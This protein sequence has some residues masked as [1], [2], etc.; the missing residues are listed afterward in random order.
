MLPAQQDTSDNEHPL[1]RTELEQVKSGWKVSAERPFRL[2]FV[3]LFSRDKAISSIW[4]LDR[5][6]LRK[7]EALEHY[8]TSRVIRLE[9]VD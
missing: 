6:L 3:P 2:P 4:A 7:F 1:T 8:S 5:W 9:K